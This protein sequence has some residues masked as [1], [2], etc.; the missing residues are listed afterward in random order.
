VF[1]LQKREGIAL[2]RHVRTSKK[3]QIAQ[4]LDEQA[5]FFPIPHETPSVLP[6]EAEVFPI[7]YSLARSA[8]KAITIHPMDETKH[9]YSS[10][11]KLSFALRS[12]PA[13]LESLSI[14]EY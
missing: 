10:P 4:S 3:I 9:P 13:S 5:F 7:P 8:I 11:H 14:I 12:D 6:S 1:P 2:R